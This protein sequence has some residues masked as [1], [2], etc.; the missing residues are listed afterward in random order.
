MDYM[1]TWVRA[2]QSSSLYQ[3]S[4]SS[5]SMAYHSQSLVCSVHQFFTLLELS[6][7]L[8]HTRKI[9]G[10][11]CQAHKEIQISGGISLAGQKRRVLA[12]T[13]PTRLT[14]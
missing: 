8:V 10:S 2:A 6:T 13:L 7:T 11:L 1:V 9:L 5:Q 4:F 3:S 14:T 12:T